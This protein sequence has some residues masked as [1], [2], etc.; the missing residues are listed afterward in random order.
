MKEVKIVKEDVPIL[1]FSSDGVVIGSVKLET[2]EDI[3]AI[4]DA[5]N[6]FLEQ[7]K[8]EKKPKKLKLRLTQK[9]A[10]RL[11]EILCR[12]CTDTTACGMC[13]ACLDRYIKKEV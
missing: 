12:G 3:E 10:K 8:Q 2:N 6:K 1:E 13:I 7:Y 11:Q 4:R 5:C 9:K